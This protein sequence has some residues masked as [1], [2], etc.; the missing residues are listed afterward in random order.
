MHVIEIDD[1][2]AKRA[3][4]AANA[5]NRSLAEFVSS[6]LSETLAKKVGKAPSD[7]KVRKFAESY[8]AIPQRAEEWDIWQSEQVW[9]DQ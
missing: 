8:S 2:L 6:A 5:E 3:T 1:S 7:E 4:A 9:E